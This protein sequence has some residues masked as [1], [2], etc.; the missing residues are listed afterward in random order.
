MPLQVEKTYQRL[1]SISSG[2][3]MVVTDL[4]GNWDIY[5]RYRDCFIELYTQGKAD[6]I[7]FVGDLIHSDSEGI[8]DNSLEIVLDILRLKDR[9]KDNVTY[10]C[11]NH[12]LPHI[13]GFG[14][15]KGKK[16]FTRPFEAALSQTPYRSQV[17]DLFRSL[18]FY[19][20]TA[21]G[22][23]I[24]HAG[25]IPKMANE[26]DALMVLNWSHKACLAKAQEQLEAMG[27]EGMRRA[28]AKLSG[29]ES[30]GELARDYLAVTGEDDPRFDDLLRGLFAMMEP[31][32][33]VMKSALFTKCESEF[34]KREYT[35]IV[36]NMLKFFSL[37][38]Q[39][40]QFLAAGHMNVSGGYDLIGGNHFR[41][42]SGKHAAPLEAGCYL[43]MKMDERVTKIEELVEKL[44]S[45]F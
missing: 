23:T 35:E 21:A 45:I 20:R 5:Q 2:T 19:L 28:Y 36:S 13:Y 30:Y 18:P 37:G 31:D 34:G 44:Y 32:F 15:G 6:G 1:W 33:K 8:P 14:L 17:I 29:V 27:V 7:I 43:L 4:H 25:A 24:T 41:F 10:L 12:E 42:A 40:Q 38:F 3:A 9:Y 11:G 16:V 39:P 22:V 26:E